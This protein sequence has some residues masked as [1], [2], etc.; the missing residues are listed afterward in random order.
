M[1]ERYLLDTN[2]AGFIIKDKP[3]SVRAQLLKVPMASVCIST[4]TQDELLLWVA[5]KPEAKS[6]TEAVNEFLLRVEIIP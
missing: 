2:M 6:L 1:E 3:K 4:I 5:K